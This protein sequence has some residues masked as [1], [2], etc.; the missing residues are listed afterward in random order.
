MIV[1][2]MMDDVQQKLANERMMNDHGF[3]VFKLN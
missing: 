2:M 3:I 1:L